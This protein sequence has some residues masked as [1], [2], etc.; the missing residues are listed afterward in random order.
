MSPCTST[1]QQIWSGTKTSIFSVR[2]AYHLEME[3]RA[4]GSSSSSVF[5]NANPAWK[6]IWKLQVPRSTQVFL[7]RAYNDILPTKEKLLQWKVV[8]EPGC[9]TCR[10]EVETSCHAFWGCRAAL[11]IWAEYGGR[12]QKCVLEDGSFLNIFESLSHRLEREEMEFVALI[13]QKIWHRRNNIVFG[14]VVPPPSYL[15]KLA[16]ET[17]ADF[18]KAQ[19]SPLSPQHEA[20]SRETPWSKPDPGCVKLNWDAAVNQADK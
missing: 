16:K 19:S 18:R 4:R 1:D 9:P 8:D 20:I 5:P 7:W 14:R 17:L 13:T 10:R 2:S 15:V 6:L 11:A 3:R 12:I